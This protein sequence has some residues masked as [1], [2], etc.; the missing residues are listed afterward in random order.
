MKS[1]FIWIDGQ[2]VPFAQ[3]TVHVLSPSIHYGPSVFEGARCYST[4]RGPATFRLREHMD[5]FI[6]S[7]RIMGFELE[8]TTEDLLAAAHETILA[9]GFE[10]C[11]IRPL[12]YLEGPLGLS[13]SA[14]TPHLCIATWEWGT[15]LGEEALEKGVHACVSSFTRM[16]PNAS[17][18]K[19]KIGGQYVNSMLAKTLAIQSGF[20]EAVLLDPEGYVAECSGENLFLVRAG[21]II[22][23]PKAAILEGITRDSVITLA[24]DLGYKVI[25]EKLSRDQLYIADEVFVCGTA[26]EVTPVSRID[27]RPIGIGQPGPVTQALQSAFFETVRGRG[28]RS[29]E[30]LDWS[31]SAAA[32]KEQKQKPLEVS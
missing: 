8:Y 5:R 26:A 21:E 6:N 29:A 2:L 3:A 22:T 25:E 31:W 16:H 19:A 28:S 18:T 14:S 15:F 17:M 1:D 30:W 11:Y 9:N 12:M 24:R 27:F 32:H 7:C 4:V 23:P 20:E 10:A 13:L